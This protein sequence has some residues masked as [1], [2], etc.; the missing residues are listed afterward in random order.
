MC[1]KCGKTIP[2]FGRRDLIHVLELIEKLTHGVHDP[3]AMRGL[4]EGTLSA[5][6]GTCPC[7]LPTTTA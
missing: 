5:V 3:A 1:V 6:R 4:V 7:T 2:Y